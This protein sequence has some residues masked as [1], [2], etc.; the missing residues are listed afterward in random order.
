MLIRRSST[1]C[2]SSRKLKVFF[3][4]MARE[5]AGAYRAMIDWA[6]SLFSGA[7]DDPNK[8]NLE[9][10]QVKGVVGDITEVAPVQSTASPRTDTM[11][12]IVKYFEARRH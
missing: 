2:S 4:S 10:D 5:S 1:C 12:P 6:T 7:D 11:S 9:S 8:V 3:S